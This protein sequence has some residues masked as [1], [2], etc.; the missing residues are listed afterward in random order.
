MDVESKGYLTI[1]EL[2]QAMVKA[3][4]EATQNELDLIIQRMTIQEENKIRYT[5]FIVAAMNKRHYV[6]R[7]RIWNLFKYMD[8]DGSNFITPHNLK[9]ILAR[10][11]T[12]VSDE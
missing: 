12:A 5:D 1:Y 10:H 3:G 7:E 9:E 6:T 2:K 4:L 11:G 8:V